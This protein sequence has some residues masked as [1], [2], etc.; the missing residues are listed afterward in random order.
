ML[1]LGL[2]IAV[3]SLGIDLIS[4]WSIVH[5]VMVP[6]RV[7]PVTGFFD[8][9]LVQNTGVSF[10]ML[11][12]APDWLLI[13]LQSAIAAGVLILITRV[14]SRMMAVAL[15]SILGGAMGNIIDRLQDRAVTDFLDFHVGNWHWPAFNI[16]DVAICFGV[17][18][19]FYAGRHQPAAPS[20]RETLK[21]GCP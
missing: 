5:W 11:S 8:I 3:L 4:K 16:A 18:L 12:G 13:L 2:P 15:A 20:D 21:G 10:G 14:N 1:R 19:L 7:I 17:G 9:V 6:P